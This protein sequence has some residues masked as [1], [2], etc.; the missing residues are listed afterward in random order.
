MKRRQEFNDLITVVSSLDETKVEPPLE[1]GC[2]AED[3]EGGGGGGGGTN[4][5]LDIS[6]GATRR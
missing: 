3:E 1:P 4:P 2:R 6:L 5:A